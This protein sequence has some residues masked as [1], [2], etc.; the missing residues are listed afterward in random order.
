MTKAEHRVI[1]AAVAWAERIAPSV[2]TFMTPL[3]ANL[4]HA[5]TAYIRS[6]A[7]SKKGKVRRA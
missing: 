5:A 3:Q 1:A 2:V 6:R 7:K 4:Y